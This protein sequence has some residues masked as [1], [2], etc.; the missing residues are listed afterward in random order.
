MKALDKLMYFVVHRIDKTVLAG[1]KV[2][3]DAESFYW[4]LKTERQFYAVWDR[5]R[6]KEEGHVRN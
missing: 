1:F 3:I 4:S 5:Q 2:Q 6:L